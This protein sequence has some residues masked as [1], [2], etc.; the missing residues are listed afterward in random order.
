MLPELYLIFFEVLLLWRSKDRK[1]R[2]FKNISGWQ[3]SR[4]DFVLWTGKIT[5]QAF[6]DFWFNAVYN[7]IIFSFPF[8]TIIQNSREKH[9]LKMNLEFEKSAKK[10]LK[11]QKKYGSITLFYNLLLGIVKKIWLLKKT[12]YHECTHGL[13]F[14]KFSLIFQVCAPPWSTVVWGLP[15]KENFGT[16]RQHAFS[17]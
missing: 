15:R 12:E 8:N 4:E 10:T 3:K 9:L 7:S 14:F 17:L 11:M 2:L 13:R 6:L 1:S 16:R 5:S